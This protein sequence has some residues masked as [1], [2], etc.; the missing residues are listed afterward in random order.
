MKQKL[1]GAVVTAA[2]LALTAAIGINTLGGAWRTGGAF[3]SETAGPILYTSGDFV[4]VSGIERAYPISSLEEAPALAGEILGIYNAKNEFSGKSVEHY[5]SDSFYRLTQ[6]WKGYPVWGRGASLLADESGNVYAASSNYV[7]PRNIMA[8]QNVSEEECLTLAKS[9]ARDTL[10]AEEGS[11]ILAAP[12]PEEPLVVFLSGDNSMGWLCRQIL[13][14]FSDSR[15]VPVNYTLLISVSDGSVQKAEAGIHGAAAFGES[16]GLTESDMTVTNGTV[17]LSDASRNIDLYDAHDEAVV[18]QE[19]SGD[20]TGYLFTGYEF[21]TKQGDELIPLSVARANATA[22]QDFTIVGSRIIYTHPGLNALDTVQSVFDYFAEYCQRFG[23]N[24]YG[25]K[26]SLI[27][28][29]RYREGSEKPFLGIGADSGF[30]SANDQLP[31][32]WTCAYTDFDLSSYK[33][34]GHEYTHA[35]LGSFFKAGESNHSKALLEAYC[36]IFGILADVYATGDEPDWKNSYRDLM[37]DSA[38]I[39]SD[40]KSGAFD[41]IQYYDYDKYISDPD[42]AGYAYQGCT[43]AGYAAALLWEDWRESMGLE[44][45]LRNMTELVWTSLFYL[46]D[47]PSYEDFAWAFY[48][49]SSRLELTKEQRHAVL[50]ALEQVHLPADWTD[51]DSLPMNLSEIDDRY[52]SEILEACAAVIESGDTSLTADNEESI[53]LRLLLHNQARIILE[54]IQPGAQYNNGKFLWKGADSV[55]LDAYFYTAFGDACLLKPDDPDSLKYFKAYDGGYTADYPVQKAADSNWSI[56]INNP[57]MD[58]QTIHLS[59]TVTSPENVRYPFQA[60]LERFSEAAAGMFFDGYVLKELNISAPDAADTEDGSSSADTA[61]LPEDISARL[62]EQYG[63]IPAGTFSFSGGASLLEQVVPPE[64][65]TGLLSADIYDYDGDGQE[66]L[67][68]L[69]LD[70]SGYETGA[71]NH[72]S[73]VTG[74]LSVYEAAEQ[75]ADAGA[76]ITPAAELSF[77]MPALPDSQCMASLQLFRTDGEAPSIYLDYYMNMDAQSFGI[78]A[79]Q[80]DGEQLFVTGGAECSEWPDYAGSLKCDILKDAAGL[81]SLCGNL[82]GASGEREGWSSGP[83]YDWNGA[84]DSSLSGGQTREYYES[85]QAELG[86]IGISETA[87]RSYLF[88]DGKFRFMGLADSCSRRPS[89]RLT[90]ADGNLVEL[91]G[92]LSPYTDGKVQL[93][94]YDDTGILDTYR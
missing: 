54:E 1:Y 71:S 49:A 39:G 80:Y 60:Y 43:I 74:Y 85:F 31:Y 45:A 13:V 33:D 83:W 38:S 72:F 46:Q 84:S 7:R 53:A 89:E 91:C 5:G 34:L 47:Y 86:A 81:Q 20:S 75:T 69:R 62:A 42:Y 94:C 51:R 65:L 8:E 76:E 52:Y 64:Q 68:T 41:L 4:G 88:V 16:D 26:Y 78:A 92:V 50:E 59:G 66:E 82:T 9:Y 15:S 2:A 10:G 70:G 12:A 79:F 90:A 27:Y 32:Y 37:P 48:A 77:S 19:W 36:D 28:N 73:S 3:S 18:T 25:G 17:I 56:E 58:L 44:E 57:E 55:S 29:C 63:V 22:I 21:Y 6:S 40:G 30:T 93:T 61:L 35:V 23:P 14:S 24:G 87:P 11:E 67:L